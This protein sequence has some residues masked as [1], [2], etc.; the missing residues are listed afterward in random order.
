[1][2]KTQYTSRAGTVCPTGEPESPPVC[3]GVHVVHFDQF[4]VFLFLSVLWCPIRFPRK[5]TFGSSLIPFVL[6]GYYVLFMY[7]FT[8][9]DVVQYDFNI[10]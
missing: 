1:M 5:M 8:Y 9:T 7:L 2:V 6:Y 10:W 3:G 4:D